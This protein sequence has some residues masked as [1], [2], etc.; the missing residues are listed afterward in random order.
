MT[1]FV[2]GDVVLV[3]QEMTLGQRRGHLREALANYDKALEHAPGPPLFLL[4]RAYAVECGVQVATELP[5]WAERDGGTNPTREEIRAAWQLPA[6]H[7]HE[8]QSLR[9]PCSFDGAQVAI[10]GNDPIV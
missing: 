8:S 1:E 6:H 5:P 10:V 3:I 7:R 9:R 2:G 4:G